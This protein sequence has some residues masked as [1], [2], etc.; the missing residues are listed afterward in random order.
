MHRARRHRAL[1]LALLIAVAAIAARLPMLAGEI[2]FQGDSTTYARVAANLLQHGCIS[3][4]PPETGACAPHWGGNQL[5]GYPALIAGA[6]LWSD[7]SLRAIAI[8]QSLLFALA[9]GYLAWSLSHS[10]RDSRIVLVSGLA[11]ALSPSLL[12]WSRVVLTETASAAAALWLLAELI[13]SWQDRRLR[14]LPIALACIAGFWL[15]YD[16]ALFAIPVALVG[17]LLHSWRAALARGFAI[18]L[19]VSLPF[20]AWSLR[21]GLQG[22]GWLPPMSVTTDGRPVARGVMSWLSTWVENQ[23]QLSASVWPLLTG[24]YA[25]IR[26]PDDVANLPAVRDLLDRLQALPPRAPVPAA[27]DEA[28]AGLARTQR[29]ANPVEAHLWLPL[30]RAVAMWGNPRVA[31]GWPPDIDGADRQRIAAL[32]GSAQWRA[33]GTQYGPAL[34][35][36]VLAN[37]WRLACLALLVAG[38]CLWRRLPAADRAVLAAALL[39]LAART[40]AFSLTPFVETRYLTAALG[41]GDVAAALVCCALW[42]MIR[43]RATRAN[44]QSGPRS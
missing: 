8:V 23:Y 19:I 30:R 21:S 35:T 11:V 14:V 5:P 29:E 44:G 10:G 12:G 34:A 38:L 39:A 28:F 3:I 25:G 20:A 40:L 7:G 6:W 17:F 27:L 9:A 32:V 26:P 37:G 16:F 33:L 1:L 22:L 13:R 31:M 42:T 41:W 36:R 24:D 15:R 18:A 43:S 2:W 4:S